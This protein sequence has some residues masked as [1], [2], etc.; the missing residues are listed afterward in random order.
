V[1]RAPTHDLFIC[2]KSAWRPTIRREHALAALAA[3]DGH[4]VHFLERPMDVRALGRGEEARAWLA[5]LRNAR[6]P[7]PEHGVSV[8]TQATLLPPH[9]GSFAEAS[10]NLLLRRALSEA[11]ATSTVVVTVPWQW[12]ATASF[13][14]RRVFDC[15]DDWETLIPKRAEHVRS[16]LRRI[17]READAVVLAD[18][19]LAE[20]FDDRKVTV[21]RNGVDEAMLRP[22]ASPVFEPRMVHAGTLSPRFD[23]SMAAALL[24]ELPEWSLELYGQCQYPGLRERP[25]AE[26]ERL[27]RDYEERVRWHGAV[28]REQLSSA[29]DHAAVTL[30][31]NK[32]ELSRGQDSM[33][34]Y[35]YAAR[36]RPTVSTAFSNRPA[37]DAPPRLR[38]AATAT[39]L[40]HA[41][42]ESLGEPHSY[43]LERRAW[44][45]KQRWSTRWSD[46]REALF[47]A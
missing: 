22:L 12:Q 18:G 39:E 2:S 37:A 3:A 23:C 21:V 35:D 41:A 5:A 32:P 38:I 16:L 40:A 9:L 42:R 47:G 44:A 15:A 34:L 11:T 43:A 33:K 24:N 27:L 1:T 13:P 31:L 36:G 25:A 26:L 46:W 19:D 7:S 4:A 8:L 17:A 45:E 14:G 28:P 20:R 29:I 6:R 30:V 10:S